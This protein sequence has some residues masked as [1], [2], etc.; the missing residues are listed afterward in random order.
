METD[1]FTVQNLKQRLDKKSIFE[2]LRL[3]YPLLKEENIDD[4]PLSYTL[5]GNYDDRLKKESDDSAEKIVSDYVLDSETRIVDDKKINELIHSMSYSDLMYLNDLIDVTLYQGKSTTIGKNKEVNYLGTILKTNHLTESGKPYIYYDYDNMMKELLN[6][7]KLEVHLRHSK[8]VLEKY[9]IDNF[10]DLT[11]DD[12][13]DIMTFMAIEGSDEKYSSDE[14]RDTEF[15][16]LFYSLSNIITD[17]DGYSLNYD[18]K[19]INFNKLS[20]DKLAELYKV[21]DLSLNLLKYGDRDLDYS[22]FM[23]IRNSDVVIDIQRLD[24]AMSICEKNSSDVIKNV[25]KVVVN[26]INERNNRFDI[27]K[28]IRKSTKEMHENMIQ[29]ISDSKILRK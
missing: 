3:S 25:F 23:L 20:S 18:L 21:L 8:V 1:F 17:Y 5:I 10:E 9:G 13:S 27:R 28:Q 14:Y 24:E 7:I 11:Y 26:K 22:A 19:H 12:F 16:R 15:S 6:M 4:N 29:E 2:I